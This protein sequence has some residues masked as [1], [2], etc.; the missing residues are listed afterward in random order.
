MRYSDADGME[1]LTFGFTQ[2]LGLYRTAR[3]SRDAADEPL[4]R[5]AM[6]A[7]LDDRGHAHG[8]WLA[9]VRAGS[10]VAVVRRRTALRGGGRRGGSSADGRTG[11]QSDQAHQ[12]AA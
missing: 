11:F 8:R 7:L 6:G 3:L 4:A 5:A 2:P 1:S 9:V 12:P 10:D